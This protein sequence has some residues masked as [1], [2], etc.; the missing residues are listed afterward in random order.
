MRR[1]GLLIGA[2]I[3][4][5]GPAL[6]APFMSAAN[7]PVEPGARR[8]IVAEGLEHP[9]SLA[10][11]PDGAMLITERPGR[12]RLV[13]E[14]KLDPAPI[15]GVPAVFAQNQGGLLD[16]SLHPR[17]SANGWVY[18]THA[19]GTAEANRTV[20]SRGKL[21]AKGESY[22]LS[23]VETLFEVSQAKRGG[24][25][26]G[27]RLTWLPN[28]TLLM[29][30][31]DGGNAPNAIGGTLTR[32]LAQDPQSHLGKL[33]NLDENG[34]PVVGN[35]PVV[36][37]ARPELYSWGHRNVQG[38]AFDANRQSVWVT[39]HGSLGGDELNRVVRGANYGWPKISNTRDYRTGEPIGATPSPRD[40]TVG[41]ELV[42]TVSVAP[43]GLTLYNGNAFPQWK[44]DLFS[45]SL[46]SQDIRRVD[47]DE[48]GKI[49]GETALR[50]GQ[51]VRDVRQG[52]DGFLYVLTD[53][54]TGRLLRFV[55]DATA[56]S[57]PVAL[58]SQR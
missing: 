36:P 43:S 37:G 20:L 31:G 56:P 47:L 24:Q 55:P 13:R 4:I 38:L 27:S 48:A 50:I 19:T 5:G 32:D 57:A 7:V 25:H 2:A 21:T 18:L 40:G 53:E 41:P 30:I 58:P 54:R 15:I 34:K 28:G 52:P 16:V 6:A 46:M 11:L 1:A 22:E 39:E 45:G 35:T 12:L 51:R 29:S 42:W 9:W 8:E 44:G 3:W 23:G 49:K 14:G 17:F 10:F 33:L 26:F